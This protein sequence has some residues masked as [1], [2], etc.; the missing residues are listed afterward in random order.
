MTAAG[1]THCWGHKHSVRLG[2]PIDAAQ[3]RAPTRV[4]TMTFKTPTTQ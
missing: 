3:T 1:E 2:S 4:G